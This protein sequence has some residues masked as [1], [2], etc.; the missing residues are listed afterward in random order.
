MPPP[1]PC[2]DCCC[3]CYQGSGL[4]VHTAPSPMGPW[5]LQATPVDDVSCQA[6]SANPLFGGS[7]S[8]SAQWGGEPTPG[9]GCLCVLDVFAVCVV[10]CGSCA[11]PC[12]QLRREHQRFS[13]A[14]AADLHCDAA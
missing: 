2:A 7:L 3:Y 14:L 8:P 1:L 9:Q 12:L 5:T 4:F 10:C 11:P 6:T 13:N